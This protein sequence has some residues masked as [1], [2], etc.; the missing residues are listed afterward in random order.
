[1][2]MNPRHQSGNCRPATKST[3][4]ISHGPNGSK[5]SGFV[6]PI[7]PNRDQRDQLYTKYADLSDEAARTSDLVLSQQYAQYA[8]HY[9]RVA[10]P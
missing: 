4:T 2:E 7:D 9:R 8:E 10:G 5:V 3:Y 1:M 6:D